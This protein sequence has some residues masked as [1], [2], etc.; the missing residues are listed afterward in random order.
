[1]ATV[2]TLKTNKGDGQ[3]IYLSN[4]ITS[5]KVGDSEKSNILFGVGTKFAVDNKGNL[6]ANDATI[7][8]LTAVGGTF[9]GTISSSATISGGTIMGAIIKNGNGSF[10]VTADGHLTC[11]SA[12]IG[13][14]KV[15]KTEIQ[16][17]NG[18]FK[19]NPGNGISSKYLNTD[20]DGITTVENLKVKTSME[21]S[22]TCQVYLDGNVGIGTKAVTKY[23]LKTNGDI[24]LGGTMYVGGDG[25]YLKNYSNGLWAKGDLISLETAK[26][27]I[28]TNGADTTTLIY[29]YLEI[30]EDTRIRIGGYVKTL[31]EYIGF[32][33]TGDDAGAAANQAFKLITAAGTTTLNAPQSQGTSGQVL[34]TTGSGNTA[35]ADLTASLVNFS[36][37]TVTLTDAD[38]G[39][40]TVSIPYTK[41]TTSSSTAYTSG[42]S[43]KVYANQAPPSGFAINDYYTSTYSHYLGTV[44]ADGESYTKVTTSSSQSNV[45]GQVQVNVSV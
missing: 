38:S 5:W 28:G 17:T 4:T 39:V 32:T 11:T 44:W 22:N 9:S 37:T 43:V 27:Q 31:P 12:T 18:G 13:G 36:N 10:E 7:N 14:W 33:V 2:F 34:K 26:L 1:M 29:G 45:S 8:N 24:Y 30:P 41:V 21:T 15:T 35:W 19:L 25:T 3:D 20:E 23:D 6:Y 16:S 40:Y 42:H